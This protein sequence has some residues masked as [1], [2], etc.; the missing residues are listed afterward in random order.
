METRPGAGD[1][2]VDGLVVLGYGDGVV[3]H[4]LLAL[5]LQ[6]GGEEHGA[7]HLPH[8]RLLQVKH[9]QPQDR[10]TDQQLARLGEGHAEGPAAPGGGVGGGGPY[11]ASSCCSLHSSSCPILYTS[12][13]SRLSGSTLT[14]KEG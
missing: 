4:V 7:L 14:K 11:L 5:D 10:V 13:I 1:G 12:S 6:V 8:G 2:Q 3:D 9:V